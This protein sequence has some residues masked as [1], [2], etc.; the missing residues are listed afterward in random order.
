MRRLVVAIAL[1]S[2]CAHK[3]PTVSQAVDGLHLAM[4]GTAVAA[5][6]LA[7]AWSDQVD[8]REEHCRAQSLPNTPEARAEC[9]GRFGEGEQIEDDLDAFRN[10]YDDAAEPL[11]RMRKAAKRIDAFIQGE[12]P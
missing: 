6:A 1:L 10:A 5:A 3:Q 9:M 8:A 7:K 11:E 4:R 2:G 12:S